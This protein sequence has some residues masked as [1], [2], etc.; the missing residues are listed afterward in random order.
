MTDKSKVT[1]VGQNVLGELRKQDPARA[2][3]AKHLF[4]LILSREATGL[5]LSLALEAKLRKLPAYAQEEF[6]D[7]VASLGLEVL[8]AVLTHDEKRSPATAGANGQS[9]TGL[10]SPGE[11][12]PI[13][14]ALA[15]ISVE[16]PCYPI[17]NH[18]MSSP[19]KV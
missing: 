14:S 18:G 5:V 13:L 16:T 19:R 17:P 1:E 3:K 15:G 8:D 4:T 12:E 7:E 6:E 9:K 11:D 10:R 2:E